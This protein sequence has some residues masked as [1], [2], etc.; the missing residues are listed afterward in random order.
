MIPVFHDQ[1][2]RYAWRRQTALA[3]IAAAVADKRP[4]PSNDELRKLLGYDSRCAASQLLRDLEAD[5][6]IEIAGRG[7]GRVVKI[8]ATGETTAAPFEGTVRSAINHAARI[9]G[10]P[11][12]RLIGASQDRKC[13]R[14]RFAI[15]L[16]CREHGIPFPQT[17]DV[18]ARDH[19][20]VIHGTER[21]RDI[22]QRDPDYAAKLDELRKAVNDDMPVRRAA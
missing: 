14:P 7:A 17:A 22:A 5:R 8:V 12:Y 15:Y 10:L 2:E 4:C 6:R 16:V 11:M 20:T 19:S 9:W 13:T 18:L 3:A 21:A 1:N